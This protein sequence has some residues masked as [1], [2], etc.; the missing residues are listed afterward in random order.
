MSKTFRI[1]EETE[2]RLEESR[3]QIAAIL[4]KTDITWDKFFNILLD[5]YLPKAK[6]D[7]SWQV[8]LKYYVSIT[9]NSA[10]NSVLYKGAPND[11]LKKHIRRV[12]KLRE[13]VDEELMKHDYGCGRNDN[14]ALAI[15][16][17]QM[18]V[19]DDKKSL[20]KMKQWEKDG[21]L[22]QKTGYG[23]NI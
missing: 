18:D 11:E 12:K 9:M 22:G 13:E 14:G 1:S 4:E 6:N 21:V 23:G 15:E 17:L 19:L 7:S 5:M 20:A 2:M 10:L 16:A 3:K 8:L